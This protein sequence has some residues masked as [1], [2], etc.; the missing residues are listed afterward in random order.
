MPTR[1]RYGLSTCPHWL[2]R[3][4]SGQALQPDRV[5]LEGVPL[6]HHEITVFQNTHIVSMVEHGFCSGKGPEFPVL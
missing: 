2:D 1:H 3:R 5:R 4:G 6:A